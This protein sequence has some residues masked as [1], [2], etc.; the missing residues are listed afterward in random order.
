[1]GTISRRVALRRARRRELNIRRSGQRAPTLASNNASGPTAA[2]G[3]LC[4]L[5]QVA[6]LE[7]QG[8]YLRLVIVTRARPVDLR[9]R[10]IELR[11]C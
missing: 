5:A 4:A 9:L 2:A 6:Q 1:M 10:L 7:V 8:G 3:R 11:F